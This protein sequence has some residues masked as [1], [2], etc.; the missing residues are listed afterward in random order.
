MERRVVRT[1]CPVDLRL[2]LGG[3]RHGGARDRTMR[4]AGADVWRATNTALGPAT[5]HLR[6]TDRCTVAARAWGPGAS[7]AIEGVP[8][9][10]GADDDPAPLARAHPLVTELERRFE[11]LRIGRTGAVFE[12]VVPTVLAQRVI[13]AEASYAYR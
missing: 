12:A 1:R 6:S 9:L 11:G 5:L 7:A 3:L 8:A 13:G 10:V 2:T 4:I